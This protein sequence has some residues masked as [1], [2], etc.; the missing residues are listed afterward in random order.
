[1]HYK[2]LDMRDT[3]SLKNIDSLSKHLARTVCGDFNSQITLLLT[4]NRGTGKSLA[5]LELGTKTAQEI[6]H[7]KGGS[8]SDYFNLDHVAIIKLDRVLDLLEN[9]NQFGVYALDDIGVGYSAREWRSDKNIRMN[10]ILQT[11]RTSNIVTLLSV[12]SKDLLDKVPREMVDRYIETSKSWNFYEYGLNLVKAFNIERLLREGKQL[13][14][15]PLVDELNGLNQYVRYVVKRP[16]ASIVE[17]YEKLRKQIADE[18]RKEEAQAIRSGELE[19]SIVPEPQAP[20]TK[21][22]ILE[23]HAV[24]EAHYDDI[25]FSQYISSKGYSEDYAKQVVSKNRKK[26]A[27]VCK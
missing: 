11:F 23:E 15:L 18:L 14:I 2:I 16:P 5:I 1:M 10:R 9:L 4:G 19:K 3:K 20:T 7:L 24:W 17:P 6:A 26:K 27:Q 22:K 8:P 25:P 21:E 12:P 13:E